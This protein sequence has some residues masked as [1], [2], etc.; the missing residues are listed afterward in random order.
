[1]PEQ[2]QA[3]QQKETITYDR[4]KAEGKK[5]PL[6][7][8]LPAHL[9]RREEI[10]EPENVPEGAKRLGKAVTELLDYT[11][12]TFAQAKIVTSSKPSNMLTPGGVL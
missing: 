9:P 7:T 12:A 4:K 11:T 3:E 5:H 8:E 6:R 2:E 1:M 10:I